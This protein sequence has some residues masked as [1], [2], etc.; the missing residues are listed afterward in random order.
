MIG[1]PG[2]TVRTGYGDEAAVPVIDGTKCNACGLCVKGCK[3]FTLV[4]EGGRPAVMPDN[5][6][7]CIGCGQCMALCP[8]GA[9]RVAGRRISPED[10]LPMPPRE[11]RATPQ[12]LENLLLA[13]RSVREFSKKEVDRKDIDRIL[14]MASSAPMGIPPS[15]VGVAV[16]AGGEKTYS[17]AG[18]IMGEFRRWQRFFNPAV[19]KIARLFMSRYN[20]EIMRD[21]ILPAT[22]MMSR[23][24]EEGTDLLFYHAPCVML[25]HQSPYADP[26]DGQIACTYA[27]LAAE[28]LGLGSCM[29]GTVSFAMNQNVKLKERWGIPAENRVAIA[30]IMGH[31]AFRYA[32]VLRRRFSSVAYP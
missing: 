2:K 31:P 9:I 16:V 4:M 26:V 21:F 5:G 12:G 30:L 8:R 19:M 27:M 22:A 1:R 18:D 32:R 24:R 14:A 13:R 28:S 10:A 25:F 3:T 17:L 29:I 11:K 20:V 7:G 6:L 23:A 15:D